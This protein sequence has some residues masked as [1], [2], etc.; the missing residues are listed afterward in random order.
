MT[1][2]AKMRVN[3]VSSHDMTPPLTVVVVCERAAA[4]QDGGPCLSNDLGTRR[5]SDGVRDDVD[6]RVEEDDLA[7][8]EL[9]W[10]T[11][12]HRST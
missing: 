1:G 6:T 11:Y 9:H 8:G 4:A 3:I 12:E 2:R 5:D 10:R 7:A